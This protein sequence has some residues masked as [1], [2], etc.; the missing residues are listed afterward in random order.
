MWLYA[1]YPECGHV[2]AASAAASPVPID[3]RPHGPTVHLRLRMTY[4]VSGGA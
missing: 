4:I 2:E 1:F 3:I